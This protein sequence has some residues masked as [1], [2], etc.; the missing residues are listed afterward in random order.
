MWQ[1]WR[2]TDCKSWIAVRR[3]HHFARGSYSISNLQFP[4]LNLQYDRVFRINRRGECRDSLRV[5]H[6]VLPAIAFGVFALFAFQ[7]ALAYVEVP[8]SLGRLVQ[9]STHIMLV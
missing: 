8:Y 9:E 6:H 3:V 1:P 7:A 4:I 5:A 2:S